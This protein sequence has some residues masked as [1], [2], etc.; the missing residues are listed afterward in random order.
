MDCRL[1]NKKSVELFFDFGSQPIVHN[2][3]K[4]QDDHLD[5]FTFRVGVCQNCGFMQLLDCIPAVVLYDNYFTISS[6]KNQ[7]HVPRLIWLIE[8]ILDINKD[9]SI[10]EIGCNDGSFLQSLSDSRYSKLFGIE[11]TKNSYNIAKSKGFE[12]INDFF[13]SENAKDIANESGKFELIIS[14]QVL[15]HIESLNDFLEGIRK[16]LKDDG[17]LLLEI[18]DSS[19]NIDFLDYAFWE[20]HVNYFTLNTLEYLLAKNGFSIIHSETLL[21]SGKALIVFAKKEKYLSDK[22]NGYKVKFEL[23]RIN[24]FKEKWSKFKNTFKKELDKRKSSRENVA[25]YGCGAR[26]STIVN[27]LEISEYITCY[28][29]DQKEKQNYHVPG[30]LLPVYPSIELIEKNINHVLLGVNAENEKEVIHSNKFN[31]KQ[32]TYES[33]LPPS[34]HIP[35][36]WKELIAL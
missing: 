3:L 8:T 12:V 16:V 34:A 30:S 23:A 6:W 1:C 20:E 2:L 10:F 32:I 24:T 26:S 22:I 5:T 28:V 11:P 14:R 7:P 9:S 13:T 36:F 25:V 17:Y 15:E 29:D 27:F 18:P 19:V 21:F 31:E 4:N 33:L 35:A